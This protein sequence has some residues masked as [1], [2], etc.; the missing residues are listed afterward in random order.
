MAGFETL[1]GQSILHYRIIEK[2]GS[3]GTGAVYKAEE[4]PSISL[5]LNF[6]P[7]DL[8]PDRQAQVRF[9]ISVRSVR[10]PI[11]GRLRWR[12]NSTRPISA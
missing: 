12:I 7:E 3:G 9:K 2:L 5:R 8:A 11:F 1:L 4:T 10:D 6:L